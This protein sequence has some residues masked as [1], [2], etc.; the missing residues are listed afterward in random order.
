[1]AGVIRWIFEALKKDIFG[2]R[3]ISNE[4]VHVCVHSWFLQ[5]FSM[6]GLIVVPLIIFMAIAFAIINELLIVFYLSR[7]HL[8]ASYIIHEI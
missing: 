1:M 8:S 2:C 7:L 3:F 6:E 5:Y 4:E